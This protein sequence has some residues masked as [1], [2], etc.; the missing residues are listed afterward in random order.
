MNTRKN[1][2]SLISDKDFDIVMLNTVDFK[3][4]PEKEKISM[5]TNRDGLFFTFLT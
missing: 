3:S 2:S 1:L 4:F 5:K